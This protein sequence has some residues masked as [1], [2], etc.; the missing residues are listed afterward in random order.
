MIY[1]VQLQNIQLI[2]HMLILNKWLRSEEQPNYV[3]LRPFM[4]YIH[5]AAAKASPILNP[6]RNLSYADREGRNFDCVNAVHTC[7]LSTGTGSLFS[8]QIYFCRAPWPV[9]FEDVILWS[10]ERIELCIRRK[11]QEATS[12]FW[13]STSYKLSW[14]LK[15]DLP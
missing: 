8:L 13:T 1:A 14:C 2:L 12:V 3:I 9:S 15:K 10:P 4:V 11:K 7:R 6:S 5:T